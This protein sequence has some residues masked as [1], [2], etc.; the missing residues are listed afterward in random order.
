MLQQAPPV[1]RDVAHAQMLRQKRPPGA[2]NALS[3]VVVLL[4][5]SETGRVNKRYLKE[6]NGALDISQIWRHWDVVYPG[7]RGE[8]RCHYQ[9]YVF[10]LRL[11][12][13]QHSVPENPA[14]PTRTTT[15]RAE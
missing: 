15:C 12:T 7:L 9:V 13:K 1:V 4:E 3:N 2:G 14:L 11:A 5:Q 6:A 8:A 10:K